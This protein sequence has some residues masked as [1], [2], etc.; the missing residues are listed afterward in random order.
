[1]K[2]QLTRVDNE[3]AQNEVLRRLPK[4]GMTWLW[5]ATVAVPVGWIELDGA[6]VSRAAYETLFRI[7]GTASPFGVGDGSTTF[8]VPDL[9][10]WVP[11][12]FVA[13]MKV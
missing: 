1:M 2:E 10:A 8:N 4:T 13:I 9:S 5:P 7:F 12:D 6:A 3:R 11:T